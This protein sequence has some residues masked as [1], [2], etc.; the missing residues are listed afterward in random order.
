MLRP[1]VNRPVC[2]G[3]EH[4]GTRDHILLSQIRD[5]PFRR[6]LRLS[7]LQWRYSTP[8]LDGVLSQVKVKVKVLL[9]P[10]V[11]SA[12]LSRNKAPIRGL[13]P[14]LYYCQTIADLLMWGALSDVRTGLSFA[15]LSSNKSLVSTYNLHF[16]SYWMHV[17]T[18]Y[19]RPLSVQAQYSRSCSIIRG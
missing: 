18:T 8:P 16:T 6:L 4:H 12:S 3:V 13:R 14:D 11:Q 10:T 5:F 15:R 19:T 1:T 7:K 9:R 2:L 17:Y